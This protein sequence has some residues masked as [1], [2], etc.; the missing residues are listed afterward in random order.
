MYVID[1]SAAPKSS[2]H[3][4]TGEPISELSLKR[5]GLEKNGIFGNN[6]PLGSTGIY[7][8]GNGYYYFSKAVSDENGNFSDVAL[9]RATSDPADPFTLA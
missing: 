2:I 5:E 7:S 8:F 6:F 3:K 4:A 9:Y 1:G